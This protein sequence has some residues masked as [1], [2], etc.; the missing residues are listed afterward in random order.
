MKK[1]YAVIKL[2]GKQHIVSPGDILTVDNF[3]K[4]VGEKIVI[5]DVLLTAD[6]KSTQIG[7]P[8]VD[9]K[10]VQLE[11]VSNQKAKKIRVAKFKS[12]S[13]YRRVRGHRTHQTTLKV[14]AIK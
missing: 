6:A 1:P 5:A 2:L 11:V 3:N 12:K 10:K 13:R 8:I 14:L 9:K 7:Q 4:P